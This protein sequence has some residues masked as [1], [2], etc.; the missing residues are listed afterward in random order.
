MF[1]VVWGGAG[2]ASGGLPTAEDAVFPINSGDTSAC[3]SGVVI[4]VCSALRS[5]YPAGDGSADQGER[6]GVAGLHTRL[7]AADRDPAGG[8][9]CARRP[10]S[11]EV[12]HLRDAISDARA[13]ANPLVAGSL[14]FRFLC[15][16]PLCT[17][18]GFNLG[19][20]SVIDQQPRELAPAEAEMLTK[21][22]ALVM[23]QM[24]LRLAARKVARTGRAQDEGATPTRS[25]RQVRS[26]SAI[27][28]TR[29]RSPMC[30]RAWIPVSSRLTTRQ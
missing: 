7:S 26:T 12:Y 25:A 24:E 21:L 1:P 3:M 16:R 22:A 28:S 29:P 11:R 4:K 2:F 13:L 20:L 10:F 8:A 14:G 30:M 6:G 18:D 17:H 15:G 27:F 19:T 5:L 23:D 9:G